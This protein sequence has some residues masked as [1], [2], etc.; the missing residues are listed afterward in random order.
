ML[1]F[2]YFIVINLLFINC[3]ELVDM[4]VC[5]S[6]SLS[7][8]SSLTLWYC[9]KIKAIQS[10]QRRVGLEVLY[11]FP[12]LSIIQSSKGFTQEEDIKWVGGSE[13]WWS[14]AKQLRFSER[15]K[16][17][18]VVLASGVYSQTRC[19]R[20]VRTTVRKIRTF[21]LR[22]FSVTYA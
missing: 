9:I 19:V 14:S 4:Y 2:Y 5:L 15:Y 16:T 11:I 1:L 8:S 10:L 3:S 21:F 22:N 18:N 20:G 17:G 12:Q 13:K 7:V 6:V